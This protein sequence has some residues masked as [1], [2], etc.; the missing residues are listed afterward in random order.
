MGHSPSRGS[1][2]AHFTDLGRIEQ[3]CPGRLA[4][5]DQ[6]QRFVI[7]LGIDDR[8]LFGRRGAETVDDFLLKNR[9]IEFVAFR[10]GGQ[11]TVI[12]S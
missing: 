1:Y 10:G 9:N 8:F 5:H 2:G 4:L 3:K 6:I 12:G 7:V 11:R